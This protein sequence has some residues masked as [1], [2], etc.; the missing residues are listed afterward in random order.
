MKSSADRLAVTVL[1]VSTSLL[2]YV[3]TVCVT[4][5]VSSPTSPERLKLAEVSVAVVVPLYDRVGSP[6]IDTVRVA[7]LTVSW[8]EPS[9][10]IEEPLAGVFVGDGVGRRARVQLDVRHQ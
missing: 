1:A 10:A 4:V 9:A 5:K 7:G 6:T 2:L 8:L 3:P